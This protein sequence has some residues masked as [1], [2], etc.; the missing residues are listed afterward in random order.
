M[1]RRPTKVISRKN[2]DVRI[3]KITGRLDPGDGPD[4][5]FDMVQRFVEEGEINFLLDLRS[6]TYISSTGVGSL[7]KCYRTVLKEKG[8][9][10]LLSPSQSVRNILAISKLDG[11]FEIFSDEAEALADFQEKAPEKKAKTRKPN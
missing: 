7:I 3:I 9:V 2:G 8:Q 5:L 10:K 4:L 6:V 11:V 1:M